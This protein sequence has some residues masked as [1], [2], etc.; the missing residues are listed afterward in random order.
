MIG[1]KLDIKYSIK[2]VEGSQKQDYDYANLQ[3]VTVYGLELGNIV[4]LSRLENF[5]RGAIK[6]MKFKVEI[7]VIDSCWA[8]YQQ[9]N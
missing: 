7:N 9:L 2:S 6:T 5:R 1:H 4:T 8:K 3:D